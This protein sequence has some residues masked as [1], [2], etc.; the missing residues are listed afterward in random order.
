MAKPVCTEGSGLSGR[1][2]LN[3]PDL[4]RPGGEARGPW[5]EKKGSSQRLG[6]AEEGLTFS[7]R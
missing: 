2:R 1:V 6:E 4:E 5:R 7:K 3:W